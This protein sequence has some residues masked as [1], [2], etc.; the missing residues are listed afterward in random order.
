MAKESP[1]DYK[2]RVLAAARNYLE[3]NGVDMAV[4]EKEA[5][6]QR[7]AR[8][9]FSKPL[10]EGVS[11][12]FQTVPLGNQEF[13]L[14]GKKG[15]GLAPRCQARSRHSGWK[16]CNAI[17]TTGFRVCLRH[18]AASHGTKTPA[19]IQRSA[20]HLL[21]HGR[22][23][24]AIRR[25]RSE[26]HKLNKLLLKQAMDNGVFVYPAARGP[27]KADLKTYQLNRAKRI[28]KLLKEFEEAMKRRG[29]GV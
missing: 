19:G 12:K 21:V 1:E 10:K 11:S 7:A 22:E 26:A 17:A 27:L 14:V 16:Q 24:R 2:H 25:R 4:V 23:T 28:A 18:G 20:A 13:R 6:Q 15:G 9:L 5:A 8:R 3:S 29:V